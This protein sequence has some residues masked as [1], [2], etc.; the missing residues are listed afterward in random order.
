MKTNLKRNQKPNTLEET[1]EE[2]EDKYE[3]GLPDY[4]VDYFDEKERREL[5]SEFYREKYKRKKSFSTEERYEYKKQK[6]KEFW[7]ENDYELVKV[8]TT[9]RKDYGKKYEEPPLAEERIDQEQELTP[10]EI[11]Y[12]IS[13]CEDD[14]Y[15]FA[16]RYFPH[17]L[18]KPS[19]KL[20]KYLYNTFSRVLSKKNLAKRNRPGTK[21]A[22]AAPRSNA[23]S[24]IVVGILP[25]WCICY[26]KKK[27][28]II[29][30]DTADQA[31]DF[32]SDIKRE[33]ESNLLLARDFPHVTGKGSIWRQDEII[34][35]NDVRVMALGTG[36]KIRGRKYGTARP[37][38]LLGDDLESPEMIRSKKEREYAENWFN[39]DFLY[40][41]EAGNIGTDI[42]IVGTTLAKNSLL[43]KLLNP[44]E[45]PG[46][47]TKRFSA[48][49]KFS[50]SHL[51]DE[52]KKIYRNRLD[53]DRV[54]N[55][56]EFFAQHK[57]E[58]LEGTEVL[59]PEGD[60]YYSLMEYYTSNPSSFFNEKQN[61]PFD[62]SKV[63]VT[64][65]ELSFEYFSHHPEIIKAI[66]RGKNRRLIFGG[67]DPSLGK[68]SS[69][70]DYS[71]ILTLIRDPETGLVFVMDIDI[72]RRSVD[73][74]IDAIIKH[75]EKWHYK[76]FA[77][78]T[79]AFQYVVAENLRKRSKK[80]GI[81]V[82][83]QE[84]NQYTDKKLRIEGIIP[85][86]KDGT[87]VFDKQKYIN[88]QMYNLGVEQILTYT[89]EGDEPDDTPDILATVF[90]IAKK[91]RFKMLTR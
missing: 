78:E 86:L 77:V 59:W 58:M 49:S 54:K 90:E 52:W 27:F 68:K 48:V 22:I 16:V 50:D 45:Y 14:L 35:N 2:L 79:N 18:K 31:Q 10:E 60:S 15:L 24:S 1:R 63:Y 3:T 6:E 70:G 83:I 65:E 82:P 29:V 30:S 61:T 44:N 37:D 51:W 62:L 4:L 66:E 56:R 73:D 34:T 17:Y 84:V 7:E 39:S 53:V 5:N 9:A 46:W 41:G 25:I 75:H 38:L 85:F 72:K 32:L 55:A 43:N 81:Y 12:L 13:I 33:L 26:N 80:E 23:K 87:I 91:P 67:I 40:A 57:E 47:D 71:V 88:F 36:N 20:H 69:K 8:K 76:L 42:F 28:M 11:K 89:G 64:K 74:Q 19:S 21:K